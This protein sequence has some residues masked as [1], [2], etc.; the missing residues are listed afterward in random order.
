MRETKEQRNMIRGG[1]AFTKSNGEFGITSTFRAD[2]EISKRDKELGF[3][4]VSQS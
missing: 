4:L 1:A 2:V 3:R